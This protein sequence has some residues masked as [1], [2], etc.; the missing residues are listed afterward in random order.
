MEG[1]NHNP[2]RFFL[3]L[4]DFRPLRSARGL[5]AGILVENGVEMVANGARK[6]SNSSAQAV[7]SFLLSMS[8]WGHLGNP[9]GAGFV[10]NQGPYSGPKPAKK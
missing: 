9:S 3:F 2:I 6:T 7:S 5:E 4:R 10:V 8:P 1:K